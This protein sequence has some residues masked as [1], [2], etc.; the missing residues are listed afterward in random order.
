MNSPDWSDSSLILNGVCAHDDNAANRKSCF[1]SCFK[2]QFYVSFQCYLYKQISHKSISF[3]DAI[4][5][6]SRQ[7][8][9]IRCNTVSHSVRPALNGMVQANAL[10]LSFFA[11]YIILEYAAVARHLLDFAPLS[12]SVCVRAS[13]TI[14]RIFRKAHTDVMHSFCAFHNCNGQDNAQF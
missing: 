3:V 11:F 12:V 7:L 6:P 14:H 13:D 8:G 4:C 5:K 2:L 1:A 9:G 10:I